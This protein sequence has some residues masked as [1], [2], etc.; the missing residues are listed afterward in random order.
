M[1][2]PIRDYLEEYLGGS[3]SAI[4]ADFHAHLETCAECATELRALAMQA[5]MLRTLCP[6]DEVDVHA[7]FYARVVDRIE[8]QRHAS[9]WSALLEPTFGRRLAVVCAMLIVLLGSYFVASELSEPIVAVAP[10]VAT[11][12]S[13]APDGAVSYPAASQ[14]SHQA[15]SQDADAI[16]RQRD[17]VLVNLAS[18]HE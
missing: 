9:I 11:R 14:A 7:G 5:E 12:S 6:V 2:E 8:A 17:A 3:A 4:P 1:H 16:E 10:V 13:S 18:F 15:S